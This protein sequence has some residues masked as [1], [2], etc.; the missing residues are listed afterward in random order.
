MRAVIVVY[1]FTGNN[2]LLAQEIAARTGAEVETVG[3][4]WGWSILFDLA[5]KRRPPIK[6]L[7]VDPAGFDRVLVIAPL[8]DRY[9]AFPMASALAALRDRVPGHDFVTLCGYERAGQTETVRRELSTFSAIPRDGSTSCM[10]AI[11]CPRPTGGT[12]A[13]CRGAVSRPR[14]CAPSMPGSPRSPRALP[15]EPGAVPFPQAG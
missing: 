3:R 6:P 15:A 14:I 4:R 2:R 7:A 11:S 5:L 1:S 12:C 9:V 10:W 8:W 13:R